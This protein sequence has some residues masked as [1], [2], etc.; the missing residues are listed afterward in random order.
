MDDEAVEM[1]PEL[2]SYE[3]DQL[4]GRTEAELQGENMDDIL[5]ISTANPHR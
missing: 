5:L 2:L 4:S 3:L 1:E